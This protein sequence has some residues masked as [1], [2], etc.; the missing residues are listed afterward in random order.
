MP[1]G[2]MTLNLT[3]KLTAF[4]LFLLA[5]SCFALPDDRQKVLHLSAG[6]ADINQKT[7]QGVYTD[8]V[9]LD[10]GATHIRAVR[11]ITISNVKNELVKAT[12][13]GDQLT[14]A[15]YWTLTT[16]DKPPL[17]AYADIIYYDSEH[18]LIQLEGHAKVEQ[19]N[20]SFSAPKISYDTIT[21][22]VISKSNGK[23]RTT[24]IIHPGKIHE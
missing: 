21:Q 5:N 9:E 10:Q 3:V 1:G 16:T 23:K 19:G 15:H 17:H 11:A 13:Y 4:F 2:N 18:H 7:H 8:G 14:Q 20:D 6:S 24:I 12:I 22:H